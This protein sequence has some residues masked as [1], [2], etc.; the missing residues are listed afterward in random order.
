[1][2]GSS[3]ASASWARRSLQA[4]FCCYLAGI[5]PV[6]VRAETIYVKLLVD[7]EERTVEAVWQRRFKDRLDR[8]FG[9][10]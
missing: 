7:E 8:S 4:L 2:P 3:S 9:D 5:L 10:H 6:A 1:M